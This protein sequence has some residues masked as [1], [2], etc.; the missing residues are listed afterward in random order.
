MINKVTEWLIDFFLSYGNN[1]ATKVG[2]WLILLLGGADDV[3][4]FW[5][6]PG[7]SYF[8]TLY[9]LINVSVHIHYN[10]LYAFPKELTRRIFLKIKSFFIWWPFPLFFQP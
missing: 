8:L 2:S 10:V 1:K 5:C 7:T 9:A 4:E 3:T 6:N